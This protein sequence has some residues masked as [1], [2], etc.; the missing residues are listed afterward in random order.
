MVKTLFFLA[1]FGCFGGAVHAFE[2]LPQQYQVTYG[3][4]KASVHIM[5]YF[6]L[7]CL[8]C[9]ESF[10][11]DFKTIKEKYIDSQNVYWVFHLHPADLLTLQSMICLEKLSPTEKRIFW[12]VLIETLEKPSEGCT[13]MQTAMEALGKPISQLQDLSY[14]KTTES[15]LSAYKYLKQTDVICDLPTLEIN[16]KIYDEFPHRKFIEKQISSLTNPQANPL[17]NK[18]SP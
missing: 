16:G 17:T 14:I 11:K 18:V 5:E 2:K 10:R 9:L 15:F 6:S 7:S 1:A 12:E 4:P 13:I 8:K 3:N